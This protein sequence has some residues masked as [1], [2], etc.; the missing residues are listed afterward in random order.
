VVSGD[1]GIPWLAPELV[2]SESGFDPKL[3]PALAKIEESNF[4]FVNR[5]RLIASEIS[6]Y[7]PGARSVLEIGCGTGSVMLALQK[8]MPHLHLVG[9]E[10]HPEGL[11]F[12]RKRL[13]EDVVLLQMD[14]RKIPAR[15][16][17]DVVGAFD[18][19]EHIEED[20]VVLA[21]IYDALRPNGGAIITV[22]Q[23][24]WLWSPADETARHVRRYA[25]GELERKLAK[26]GFTIAHSTSFNSLLLP[27]MVLSRWCSAIRASHN[28]KSGVLSELSLS[29]W[30]NRVLSSILRAEVTMTEF[31]V[32]WPVGGSRLVVAQRR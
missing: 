25:R 29:G 27:L 8:V 32:C 9:S 22:P 28:E 30:R 1:N 6:A 19:I 18:V 7:F 20:D 13:G 10:L 12:A 4:W 11:V 2:N 15:S 3:F 5:A 14:A 16:E 26:A 17:F 23:H 31:G 24:P 21:G